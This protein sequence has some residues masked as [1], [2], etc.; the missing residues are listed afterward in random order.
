[1]LNSIKQETEIKVEE[2]ISQYI[3]DMSEDKAK[4][5]SKATIDCETFH[6]L[7]KI[8]YEIENFIF[9]PDWSAQKLR[10]SFESCD[11]K[12]QLS[13]LLGVLESLPE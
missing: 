11:N 4:N 3:C 13:K 8:T 12:T 7:N 5:L 1:M 2:E 9:P 10:E 6:E